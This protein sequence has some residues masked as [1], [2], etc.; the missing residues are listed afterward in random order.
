MPIIQIVIYRMV[1]QLSTTVAAVAN[2][3][4]IALKAQNTSNS[5]APRDNGQVNNF[6][7]SISQDG[8]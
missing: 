4:S 2:V 3:I 1:R 8:A 7:F 6:S 5:F